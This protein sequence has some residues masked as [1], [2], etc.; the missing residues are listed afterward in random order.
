MSLR[1]ADRLTGISRHTLRRWLEQSGLA[2]PSIDRGSKFMV[3][4]R[5][6]EA[7]IAAHA[8]VP[9]NGYSE[10]MTASEKF[11]K[12]QRVKFSEEGRQLRPGKKGIDRIATVCGF[13]RDGLCVGIVWDGSKERYSFHAD[14]L[15]LAE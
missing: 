14:F 2:L 10:S 7:A 15:E 8:L 12:G 11:T 6:L 5:D 1:E 9:L 4:V 13:S 3:S